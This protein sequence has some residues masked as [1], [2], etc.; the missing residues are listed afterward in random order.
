MGPVDYFQA[1][2]KFFLVHDQ[3]RKRNKSIVPY[4]FEFND[5]FDPVSDQAIGNTIGHAKITAVEAPLGGDAHGVVLVAKR[6]F[7]T[8]VPG[9]L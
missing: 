6:V 4:G 5:D 7:A 2:L 1:D 8:F 9:H 3:F